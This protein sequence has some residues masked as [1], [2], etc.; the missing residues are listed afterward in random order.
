MSSAVRETLTAYV[1][2]RVKADH[3]VTVVTAAY[4]RNGGG[5]RREALRPVLDVI[6]RASPGVVELAGRP[7]GAGFAVRPAER[8][9]PKQ[10]EPD[11]RRAIETYLGEGVIARL[12]GLFRRL[13]RAS[14]WPPA[15]PGTGARLGVDRGQV[16]EQLGRVAV[17]VVGA[18]G[19]ALQ[20]D[21]LE[22]FG[23]LRAL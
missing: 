17:A 14:A 11:L 6:E 9:F 7:E 21:P 22:S 16:G 20:H 18:L 3:V 13:F 4:Y 10:C 5:R 1:A 23:Q 2:G 8:P 15:P 19:E 12:A